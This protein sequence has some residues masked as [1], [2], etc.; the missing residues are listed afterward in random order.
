M[1]NQ[2]LAWMSAG[3]VAAGVSMAMI[4]GAGLATADDGATSGSTTGSSTESSKST[5]NQQDSGG[6]ATKQ[7]PKN[8]KPSEAESDVPAAESEDGETPGPTTTEK[9]PGTGGHRDRGE[10][11]TNK[12]NKKPDKPDKPVATDADSESAVDKADVKSSGDL[13][14]KTTGAQSP[15]VKAE[16]SA[17]EEQTAPVDEAV[18]A[19]EGKQAAAATTLAFAAV[20]PTAAPATPTLLNIVGSFLWGLFDFVS[21]SIDFPP[22]VAPD[23]GVTAGRS[24][25]E[26]DCGDGFTADA[27]WYFPTERQPDKFI[28]FQHGFPGRAGFYNLTLTELAER[29][30]AI[31]FAPSITAN[32]FACDGCRLMGDPMHAALARLFEGDR[33]ALVA[34]AQAAGYEGTLP[35]QF[36]ISGQ[37]AGGITAAGTAGYFEEFAPADEKA[38][39]VGVLLFDTADGG[40]LSR[41]L[42]E[43]PSTI[44]VLHIAG[45]PAPINIFGEAS[46]V[47]TA[48]RPGQFNGVQLVGG[49]HGDA[50]RSSVL[51][52]I[53]QLIVSAALGFSTP[54]N[55]EAVQVLSQGWITDMYAGRVYDPATR[56]GIYGDP[57]QPGQVLIDIPTDAGVAHGYVLPGPVYRLTLIDLLIRAVVNSPA[58]IRFDYCAADPSAAAASAACS[59]SAASAA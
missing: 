20:A 48:K 13:E 37:S 43:I 22:V 58:Y 3:V 1:A 36:V 8:E 16:V 29:N 18:V 10:P 33:A 45:E 4:A 23:S 31:V 57:G 24:T 27:D 35:T 49:V 11:A 2:F 21:K 5:E 56:T 28:Y 42:D 39:M 32:L 34:S 12:T 59:G 9:T 26:I 19:S 14:P 15:S 46:Q 54:E 30:N 41:A 44:P 50:F 38:N 51:F 6:I 55:V 52:G 17:Q 47:L 25:V 53:P 7:D 40:V